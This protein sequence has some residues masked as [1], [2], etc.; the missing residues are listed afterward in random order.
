MIYLYAHTGREHGLDSLRRV[1]AIYEKLSKKGLEAEILLNDFR[2]QRVGMDMGLPP[3]IPIESIK[4]I[5]AVAKR[6][7]SVVI[8]SPEDDGGRLEKFVSDFSRVVRVA[9][10]SGDGPKY[11]EIVL[12]P[13][14]IDG[15]YG[16]WQFRELKL[17]EVDANGRVLLYYGDSD[18]DLYLLENAQNLA[19]DSVEAIFGE[20]FYVKYED[21]YREFFAT[22]HE[23]SEYE[24]LL[25]QGYALMSSSLQIALEAALNGVKTLYLERGESTTK[26]RRVLELCGAFRASIEDRE[27]IG[28]F[29]EDSVREGARERKIK[30]SD[31][32]H[33]FV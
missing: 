12:D 23:S 19:F 18:P 17:P 6:G 30:G 2:A 25:L 16:M 32:Y 7:D 8:D 26:I 10:A 13:L 1:A 21:S 5:D 33:L 4:D 3:A 31:I 14:E 27:A 20:Y 24:T 28:T 9:T 11:G 29:I 22:M 15:R